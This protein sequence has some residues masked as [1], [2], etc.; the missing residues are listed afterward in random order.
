MIIDLLIIQ[1]IDLCN[2]NC[3]YCYLPGRRDPALM[4]DSVLEASIKCTFNSSLVEPIN[5]NDNLAIV[6]HSGEPLAAGID[7]YHKAIQ[8]IKTHNSN[9]IIVRNQIQTNATLINQ[10]WCD[11]FVANDFEV[12]VSLD[13]PQFLHDKGSG[14]QRLAASRQD[15]LHRKLTLNDVNSRCQKCLPDQLHKRSFLSKKN[16]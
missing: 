15:L 11:F 6:W 12:S 16:C 14:R 13:G 1:P 3:S 10:A 7:F 9:N 5:N 4:S 2:L 8:L